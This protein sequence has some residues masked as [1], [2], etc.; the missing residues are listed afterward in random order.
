MSELLIR[1][2]TLEDLS[3]LKFLSER[4]FTESFGDDNKEEDLKV[5]L[6]ENFSP[7]KL[8]NELSNEHSTFYIVYNREEP[9]AYMKVNFEEAHTEKGYENSLEVQRIYVMKQYKGQKI[10]RSLMEK[11][12]ELGKC[13]RLDYIWLGVWEKNTDA[14]SFYKKLGFEKTG[15]HIFVIGEDRQKDYIMKLGL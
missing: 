14:L 4:T 10:G 3:V 8:R 7:E 1:E 5:Y 11:A 6:E 12:V 13:A 2:C 9:A 15:E